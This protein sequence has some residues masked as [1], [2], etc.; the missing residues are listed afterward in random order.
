MNVTAFINNVLYSGASDKIRRHLTRRIVFSNVIYLT[1]PVVYL[2]FMLLDIKAYFKAPWLLN[3][4]QLTVPLLILLCFICLYLNRK[5]FSY[6]G[7]IT[8]VILW[9]ALM[10]ILPVIVQYTPADYYL[11]YPLGIIFHA[12]LIQ[13]II[14]VRSERIT[15]YVMMAISLLL[16][17]S[18]R[19]FLLYY[20]DDLTINVGV[21]ASEYY[22]LV[23]VLYWL[24]FNT[25]T[26]YVTKVLDRLIERNDK[27]Q[28]L[29]LEN[30]LQLLEL[31]A[32]IESVNKSLEN[33]VAVRTRELEEINKKLTSYAYY[34]AHLIRG[35]F[36]RIKGI[37]MLRDL[38]AI[39][40]Y[41]FESKISL[42][43]KELE[44]A[45]D[46]MQDKLNHVSDD[47]Y[48]GKRTETP[49]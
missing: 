4:D 42:S 18:A 45:I 40:N 49:G 34:N 8:F 23:A 17:V 5:G 6:I 29:L 39:D 22:T 25:I 27:Q 26:Y 36:C 43:M 3:I 46:S 12:I 44:D 10:H 33:K 30:N 21:V 32:R 38:Q 41:D 48:S 47:Q 7:R 19:P 31:N 14:S 35:P 9:P 1:L 2:A 11:A 37:L 13:L 16:I 28:A 20:E 24:L 15:F